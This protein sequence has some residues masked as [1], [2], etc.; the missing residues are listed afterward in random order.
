MSLVGQSALT[1]ETYWAQG[2]LFADSD[3]KGLFKCENDVLV[4]GEAFIYY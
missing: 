1:Y 3:L 2:V 4:A